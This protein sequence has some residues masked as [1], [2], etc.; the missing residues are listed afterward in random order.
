[1]LNL[2]NIAL[3]ALVSYYLYE[4]YEGYLPF[5]KIW[6]RCLNDLILWPFAVADTSSYFALNSATVSQ[7]VKNNPG[8]APTN[9]YTL[10]D[11]QPYVF[12]GGTQIYPT[13][14]SPSRGDL[15]RS[16][17][18]GR[19]KASRT[20]VALPGQVYSHFEYSPAYVGTAQLF[21]SAGCGGTDLAADSFKL[22]FRFGRAHLSAEAGPGAGADAAVP[23]PSVGGDR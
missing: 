15:L 18:P 14:P 8:L 20:T 11:N 7:I 6:S 5:D 19:S 16:R 4:Y 1:L 2:S 9:F 23:V 22:R 21:Q 13:G 12:I 10:R 17:P 3:G